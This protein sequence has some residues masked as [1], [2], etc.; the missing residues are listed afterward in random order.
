MDADRPTAAA[1][2]ATPA[3][4]AQAL[5][6]RI[7]EWRRG[8][9]ARHLIDLGIH[10]GLFKALAEAPG[11][12]SAELAAGL[13]LHPPYVEVWCTAA[14]GF[15]LLDGD[16]ER[17]FRL[18]PHAA[19]TH[20]STLAE[21]RLPEFRFPL[22]TALEEMVWGNRVPTR[23]EQERLLRDAGFTGTVGRTLLGQG[24]TLLSTRRP[25]DP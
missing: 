25:T 18:A 6:S 23:E 22:Q 16:D 24:F 15:E 20:P 4:G 13:G 9:N 5:V 8:F 21:T 19:E 10:L 11:S 3:A 12:R 1:P 14:C 17:R 2:P 7:F